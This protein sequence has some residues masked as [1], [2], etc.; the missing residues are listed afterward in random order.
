MS[1]VTLI[2]GST[3]FVG[4]HL[5]R[6]ISELE[7]EERLRLLVRESSVEKAR[8]MFSNLLDNID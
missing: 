5:V 2:T 4:S 3:G 1:G 8:K 7:P 6:V